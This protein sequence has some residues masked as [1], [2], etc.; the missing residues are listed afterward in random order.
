MSLI[1][2]TVIGEGVAYDFYSRQAPGI[3]RGDVGF[4]M[5]RGELM[6]FASN[7]KRWLDGYREDDDTDTEATKW[8]NLIECLAGLNGDFEE[9]YAVAPAEYADEKTG[10]MK[11]WTFAANVCKAWREKQGE[12]EVIKSEMREKAELAVAALETDAEVSELFNA[13]QTQVMIVGLWKDE[14]TGLGV[15]L[16][17]LLD[18]VPA[19]AN[20]TYGK[21]LA[22]FKTARN[23]CPDI[24]GRVVDDSGYDVQAALGMLLYTKATG[25]DRTDW[26]WPL[27]ENVHPYHVV[28][29]MPAASVE[30]I[31]WGRNKLEASLALYAGCCATRIWPSYSTGN[32][33]V[34][35]SPP[36]QLVGPETVYAYRE[37][38]GMPPDRR[39]YEHEKPTSFTPSPYGD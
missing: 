12:R 21:C 8:G 2:A 33:M 3:K 7:P 22:D 34:L 14:E 17:C 20:P 24:W 29:P 10:K 39:D 18:L 38:G 37:S 30:F 15:P 27:Q 25:E 1:S 26:L 31:L 13:S 23:G 28:K 5:S 16:R 35:T 19:A 11:P 9:R 32:R 6:S 36:C 4:V